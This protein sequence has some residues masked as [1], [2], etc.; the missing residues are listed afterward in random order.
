MNASLALVIAAVAAAVVVLRFM[1]WRALLV[2]APSS[3]RVEPEDPPGQAKL[4]P[5]LAKLVADLEALGFTELGTHS[6]CP[7]LG[8]QTLCFDFARAEDRTF[9]TAWL[10]GDDTPRLFFL[11]VL[12]S[13]GSVITANYRRPARVIDGQY[14]S[15]GLENVSPDR[16]FKAHVRLLDGRAL[17]G[18]FTLDG[19]V[20][21]ARAW[22]AGAGRAEVRLQ[23]FH[24]LLWSVGTLGMVAAAILA[25]R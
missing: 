10:A 23:N 17:S 24:G 2:F 14:L 21:A 7:P 25:N 5:K 9:A 13:G 16:L 20:T 4:P 22:Y 8:P 18:D 1:L 11:S 6:E 19:R 3:V 12:A 15:G